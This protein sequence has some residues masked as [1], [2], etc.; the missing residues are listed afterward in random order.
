MAYPNET[1]AVEVLDETGEAPPETTEPASRKT[2]FIPLENQDDAIANAT[3][4]DVVQIRIVGKDA[5]GAVEVEF[6][7]E[8]AGTEDEL[9]TLDDVMPESMG[10]K[11]MGK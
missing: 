8:E 3:P 9:D 1:E 4:G 7:S 10:G 5:D 11:M 6:A 2:F